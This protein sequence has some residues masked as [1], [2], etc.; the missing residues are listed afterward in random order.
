MPQ[1]VPPA[2]QAPGIATTGTGVAF[3][4]AE[5]PEECPRTAAGQVPMGTRPP[6]LVPSRLSLAPT[7]RPDLQVPGKVPHRLQ[8]GPGDALPLP[9]PSPGHSVAPRGDVPRCQK[10]LGVR[11]APHRAAGTRHCGV[12]APGHDAGC[13]GTSQGGLFIRGWGGGGHFLKPFVAHFLIP[14]SPRRTHTRF[15][16]RSCPDCDQHPKCCILNFCTLGP[17]G[18][19]S[20]MRLRRDSGWPPG[21]FRF[22]PSPSRY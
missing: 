12:R 2:P 7:Q 21:S 13:L 4:D 8:T 22:L 9:C 1:R 15:R 19:H 14:A 6:R 5:G 3:W 20:P 16:G 10:P 18:C 17:A 11:V